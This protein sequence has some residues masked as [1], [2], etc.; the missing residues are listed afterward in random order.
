MKIII[1]DGK[2]VDIN[3][4]PIKINIVS[5]V[6]EKIAV[7]VRRLETPLGKQ[8]K[9]GKQSVEKLIDLRQLV[10]RLTG[11]LHPKRTL[12]SFR[13]TPKRPPKTLEIKITIPAIPKFLTYR[14]LKKSA[15][16]LPRRTQ[17]ISLVGIILIAGLI[18]YGTVHTVHTKSATNTVTTSSGKTTKLV[19][20][21]PNFSTI[22]PAG[23]SISG[24]G[25]WTRVSPPG[26]N[27][28]FAYVD[29]IG[30]VS[31]AVSEQPLPANFVADPSHQIAQLAQ[32]FNATEKITAG[33]TQVYIGTSANGPQS[34][35]LAKDSLLILIKSTSSIAN[36]QWAAYINSLQ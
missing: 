2:Q 28:V 5:S 19:Q 31:V 22:L 13:Q 29:K 20:G 36:N 3:P 10:S 21:S 26:R 23:K 4:I 33:G 30:K 25:G 12:K 8:S 35:I 17:I 11:T 24:L 18:I 27:P 7:Q 16:A 15:L 9:L 32:G 1:S 14:E 6:Q 34:V